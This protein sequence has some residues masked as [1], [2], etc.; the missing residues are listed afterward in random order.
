MKKNFLL[1]ITFILIASNT[2][3]E[4]Y[5]VIRAERNDGENSVTIRYYYNPKLSSSSPTEIKEFVEEE[6]VIK[7]G[8]KIKSHRESIDRSKNT[9][10]WGYDENA[11]I[12]SISGKSIESFIELGPYET[13]SIRLGADTTVYKDGGRIGTYGIVIIGHF[14]QATTRLLYIVPD[15]ELH[16]LGSTLAKYDNIVNKYLQLFDR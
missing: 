12:V 3:T 7:Y 5:S 9:S 8:E 4:N 10:S 13:Y 2:F 16:D 6:A 15:N 14:L 11:V 1:C